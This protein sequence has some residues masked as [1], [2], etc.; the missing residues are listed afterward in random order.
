MSSAIVEY[1]EAHF[2]LKK[3]EHLKRGYRNNHNTMLKILKSLITPHNDLL[4]I[5]THFFP[6]LF[7]FIYILYF[8][9]TTKKENITLIPMYLY[10]FASLFL[11]ICSSFYHLL[12]AHSFNKYVLFRKM[13]YLG[14]ATA[15]YFMSISCYYYGFYFSSHLIICYTFIQTVGFF[16]MLFFILN[17]GLKKYFHLAEILFIV[18][19]VSNLL[20]FIHAI[21]LGTLANGQNEYIDINYELFLIVLEWISFFIGFLFFSTHFPEC[22]YPRTFDIWFNSHTI[23]HIWVN[24]SMSIHFIGLHSIFEKR[25]NVYN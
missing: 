25:N 6:V 17:Q 12:R 23:W 21:I 2:W 11:F 20:P 14:I 19:G 18:I 1:E 3:N 8:Y 4:N 16:G 13:D 9:F 15:I 22:K 10:F 24:I 5:W 7:F